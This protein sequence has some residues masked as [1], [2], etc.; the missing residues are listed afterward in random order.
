MERVELLRALQERCAEEA[1]KEATFASARVAAAIMDGS[2]NEFDRGCAKAAKWCAKH[3]RELDVE[4]WLHTSRAAPSESDG[5]LGARRDERAPSFVGGLLHID[6]NS[7]QCDAEGR[8]IGR[9]RDCNA[10]GV[11]VDD[12]TKRLIDELKTALR[13][14]ANELNW[15]MVI[16]GRRVVLHRK[17]EFVSDI[18]RD[19]GAIARTA[20]SGRPKE[21][22]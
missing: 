3:I 21:T 9:C 2:V 22:G 13:F 17:P 20:L 5:S 6:D 7:V 12:A 4:A 8:I 11:I 18:E 1:D 19:A 15:T 16:D 10:P 14:Y